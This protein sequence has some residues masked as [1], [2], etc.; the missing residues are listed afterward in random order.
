MNVKTWTRPFRA[1]GRGFAAIGVFLVENS[2]I[3]VN[4]IMD[5]ILG[6]C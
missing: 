4:F 6:D 3:V 1:V 5:W 2:D